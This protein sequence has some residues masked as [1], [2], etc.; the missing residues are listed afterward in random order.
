MV[1]SRLLALAALATMVAC[2]EVDD[3]GR[4]PYEADTDRFNSLMSDIS[5]RSPTDPRTLPTNGSATYAGVLGFDTRL[6]GSQRSVLGDLDLTSDF[7]NNEVFGTAGDFHTDQDRRLGG[8][9]T[10]DNGAIRRRAA[11]TASDP[12]FV[13][14]VT[15]Q[16][17]SPGGD[18]LQYLGTMNG[19][20]YGGAHRYVGGDL[21]GTVFDGFVASNADGDF[22]AER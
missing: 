5:A 17:T 7:R 20:F 8:A 22:A 13:A 16:L 18:G 10:V 9:L 11:A 6:D 3:L 2:E 19:N 1:G 12:T 15:G 14:T 4:T 21:D